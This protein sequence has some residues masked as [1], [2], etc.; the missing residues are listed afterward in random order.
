M[1][2]AHCTRKIVKTAEQV[3]N[4]FMHPGCV[5]WWHWKHYLG[6]EYTG[7]GRPISPMAAQYGFVKY[8]PHQTALNGHS[9]EDVG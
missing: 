8:D 1:I 2:C 7:K 9:F 6:D 4:L 5:K 3:G